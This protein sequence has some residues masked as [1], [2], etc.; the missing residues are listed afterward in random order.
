MRGTSRLVAIVASCLGV[1]AG[2]DTNIIHCSSGRSVPVEEW[3]RCLKTE[4]GGHAML[5]SKDDPDEA[6]W[7]VYGDEDSACEGSHTTHPVDGR[8]HGDTE[9]DFSLTTSVAG[10]ATLLSCDS[11]SSLLFPWDH[12]NRY[13]GYY[14]KLV[15]VRGTLAD[16]TA[17]A[18]LYFYGSDA[19][20]SKQLQANQYTCSCNSGNSQRLMCEDLTPIPATPASD[21]DVTFCPTGETLHF[22]DGDRCAVHTE[23]VRQSFM[24]NDLRGSVEDGTAVG[25]LV[26]FSDG[27][28]IS[29]ADVEEISCSC[30]PSATAR[31]VCVNSDETLVP[32]TPAPVPE[33]LGV[34]IVNCNIVQK[35]TFFVEEWDTCTAQGGFLYKLINEGGSLIDGTARGVF[36]YYHTANCSDTPYESIPLTCYCRGNLARF[37]CGVP[38]TAPTQA[39]ATLVPPGAE[40]S[41]PSIPSIGMENCGTNSTPYYAK[42]WDTCGMET[43]P[44]KVEKVSGS[45]LDGTAHG[46]LSVFEVSDT[47]C[48]GTTIASFD[49]SCVCPDKINNTTSLRFICGA[50]SAPDTLVPTQAPA[51]P[52]P[53]NTITPT[54]APATPVPPPPAASIGMENCGTNGI[55]YAK[56]WDTCGMGAYPYKVEKVNGS[57]LDGTAHGVLSVFE[58][59]DTNCDGT[60]I[61]S[62]N[63]S[64]VC[65]ENKNTTLRFVCWD[66]AAPDTLVPTL[67]PT[68]LPTLVPPGTETSAPEPPVRTPAPIGAGIAVENCG[69]NATFYAEDW[70]TCGIDTYPYRVVRV[71]GSLLDGTAHGVLSVFK[72][73]DTNCSGIPVRLVDISCNCR[74]NKNNTMRFICGATAAPT[75]VPSPQRTPAPWTAAP[76][77]SSFIIFKCTGNELYRVQDWDTCNEMG[78]H[79]YKVVNANSSFIDSGIRGVLYFFRTAGCKGAPY[80]IVFVGCHCSDNVTAEF[81]C[82]A[83]APVPSASGSSDNSEGSITESSSGGGSTEGDNNNLLF[84]LLAAAG[85]LTVGSLAV[86]L[87]CWT[88]RRREDRQAVDGMME[89]IC[90]QGDEVE[91]AH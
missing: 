76:S 13:S 41:A 6:D 23:G 56:D 9:S 21:V 60:I 84:I 83:P 14:F 46:V 1:A 74:D 47:N 20:C 28:C 34:H 77:P 88:K 59:S 29:E 57:L 51:T 44:Y 50:T 12:C 25:S 39:P 7:L 61:A 63:L 17:V 35:K 91:M 67:A 45:L 22:G 65:P 38:T 33:P 62:F 8:C 69:T 43:Y 54:Q 73:G 81:I 52:V 86:G 80:E 27:N 32:L 49:L 68:G 37:V 19:T 58:V 42:D 70:D 30:T 82:A 10:Y 2:T 64:C 48:D 5:V 79:T 55:S 36:N 87:A 66:T 11:N 90:E 53:S 24:L 16:R 40:T 4:D 78:D 18:Y 31:I 85:G 71:N 89:Y 15:L 26:G 72:V 75:L 3:D